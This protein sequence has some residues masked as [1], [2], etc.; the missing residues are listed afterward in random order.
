[1]KFGSWTYDGFRLDLY[2]F[3][4]S[5][6][7]DKY[8]SSGEWDLIAIPAERNEIYYPCCPEHY[9]DITYTVIIRRRTLFYFI[10]LIIPCLLITLLTILSFYLPPESGE[11]VTLVITI[12][13]AMTVFLLLVAE[14]MPPTSE[15]VPLIGIYYTAAMFEISLS[16][17]ATCLT[18]KLYYRH[19]ASPNMSPLFRR[20]VFGFLAKLLRSKVGKRAIDNSST[21]QE[22]LVNSKATSFNFEPSQMKELNFSDGKV[23][24]DMLRN[25]NGV[26]LSDLE[27]PNKLRSRVPNSGYSNVSLACEKILQGI[28]IMANRVCKQEHVQEVQEEWQIAAMIIDNAFFWLFIFI[29][30]VSTVAIFLSAPRW[31][32]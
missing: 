8:V 6:D 1:M 30:V 27:S 12:L 21:S 20:F 32:N 31:Y 2:N 18:L 28:G 25:G 15:V 5:A 22:V 23:R 19:P 10:N 4:G 29:I 16:L 3:K 24:Q 13:L 9:P 26:A 7:L 17:V 11:R 14:S